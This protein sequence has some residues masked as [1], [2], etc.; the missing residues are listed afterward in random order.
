M[1]WRFSRTDVGI[2]MI[3]EFCYQSHTFGILQEKNIVNWN[4]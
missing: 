2:R 3:D 4:L 1:F